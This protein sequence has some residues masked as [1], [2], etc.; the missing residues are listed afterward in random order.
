MN[1]D[2]LTK[3]ESKYIKKLPAISVGD[4]VEVHTIVREKNRNRIQ[5]FKGLIISIKGSGTRKTFTVRKISAGI[6]VEKIFPLYSPNIEK[7]KITRKGDVR[8]S[9]LYYLR[10]R[11]GKKA[12]KVKTSDIAVPEELEEVA[13]EA[14]VE[15]VEELVDEKKDEKVAEKSETEAPKS[16]DKKSETTK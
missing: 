8:S 5:I 7:I 6:G 16:D 1:T 12:L 10:D 3:I 14:K 15:E 4:Q 11:V 2:L 13:V 9:K